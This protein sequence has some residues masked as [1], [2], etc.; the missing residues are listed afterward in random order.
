[1]AVGK[2]RYSRYSFRHS[3]LYTV[4]QRF[5][6]DF[7]PYTTLSY[8]TLDVS[9]ASVY[10]LAPLNFRRRITRPVSYYALF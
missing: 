7:T 3:H 1:M 4:H 5:R 9:Q 6:S 10:N 8:H 2:N